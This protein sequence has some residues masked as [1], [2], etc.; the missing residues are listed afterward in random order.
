MNASWNKGLTKDTHSS[1]LKTSRTMK[2]KK[3]D[4]FKLWRDKMKKLGKI[5]AY[6]PAFRKDGDLAELIGVMLGD[7]HIGIFPR[8][9]S[10]LLFS[11]SNNPGFVTRY[12]ALIERV[13]NKK[14]TITKRPKVNCV[15]ISLYENQISKRLGIPSGSRK[16]L[17]V[18]MP[19][20]IL[21]KKSY[22]VRYL[23]GLYEAEGSFCTHPKTYTYKMLFSNKNEL[24]LN[25]VLKALITLGFHPHRSE[26]QVQLS[27]KNEVFK[28]KKLIK[29]RD[30]K[31]IRT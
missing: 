14:P 31:S 5:K 23:R 15:K 26:V 11:N 18:A 19:G 22:I 9:E 27:R 3:I 24:L 30:Y 2:L 29:F 8:T 25:A 1:V 20:W 16:N 21:E 17:K 4:N 7:G 10:L 13:F 28:F 6:Y 12:A